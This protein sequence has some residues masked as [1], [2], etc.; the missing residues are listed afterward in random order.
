MPTT[1]IP[2][3]PPFLL[4]LAQLFAQDLGWPGIA[5]PPAASGSPSA[6]PEAPGAAAAA[7][8]ACQCSPLGGPSA[9]FAPSVRELATTYPVAALGAVN[10]VLFERHGQACCRD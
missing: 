10:R 5:L 1:L 7:A 9:P 3:P 8:A 4:V 2:S 6:L